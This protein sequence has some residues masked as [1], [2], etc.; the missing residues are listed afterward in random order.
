MPAILQGCVVTTGCFD[1]L[2]QGHIDVLRRVGSLALKHDVKA[3]VLLDDDES[4][5]RLKGANRPVVPYYSRHCVLSSLVWDLWIFPFKGNTQ[6]IMDLIK[7][8]IVVKGGDY[9]PEDVVRW[10]GSEVVIV[11]S[12]EGLSTTAL[13]ER[14]RC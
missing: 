9:K 6:E 14:A 1:I 11:P 5:R 13:I 10:S 8:K 4:V 2:H 7:P 3:V 12:V